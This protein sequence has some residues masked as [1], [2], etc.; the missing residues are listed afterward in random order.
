MGQMDAYVNLA[1]GMKLMEPALDLGIVTAMI[2]SFRNVAL[3]NRMIVF[4]EV[5]L[6]GEVRGVSMAGR[7]LQEA[8]KLGFTTCVMPQSNYESLSGADKE[9]MRVIGVSNV[10][11]VVDAVL[12]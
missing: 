7:R 9:G 8:K 10:A 5:G 1:G 11:Q 3:D 12:S 6:C 2:S 4:G